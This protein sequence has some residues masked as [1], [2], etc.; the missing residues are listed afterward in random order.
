M[1]PKGFQNE[2][3][4]FQEN[5]LPTK[6]GHISTAKTVRLFLPPKNFGWPFDSCLGVPDIQTSPWYPELDF[7]WSHNPKYQ[8]MGCGGEML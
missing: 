8:K 7:E 2:K 1:A 5:W 4:R 6:I 3:K